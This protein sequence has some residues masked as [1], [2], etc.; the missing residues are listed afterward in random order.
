MDY[1][2]QLILESGL[3]AAPIYFLIG[4]GALAWAA[5]VAVIVQTQVDT[6]QRAMLIRALGK[7]RLSQLHKNQQELARKHWP[8]EIAAA[9]SDEKLQDILARA[10]ERAEE[11]PGVPSAHAMGE[12]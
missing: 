8:K 12:R 2:I 1:L 6:W 4:C 7:N 9:Q 11:R 3:E 10:A 5:V